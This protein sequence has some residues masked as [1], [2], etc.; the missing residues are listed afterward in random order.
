MS[1]IKQVAITLILMILVSL[2]A[3][4]ANLQNSFGD[5]L[6]KF[7]GTTGLGYNTDNRSVNP[8]IANIITVALSFLGV[9]FLALVIYGGII[10]MTAQGDDKKVKT[11]RDLITAAVIGLII[12]VVA[13]A[14]TYLVIYRLGGGLIK[15]Q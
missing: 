4:A 5:Y 15:I 3:H 8:V 13:Y 1:C 10:W 12:V 9:I 11:A 2:P 6:N 7:A 14:V